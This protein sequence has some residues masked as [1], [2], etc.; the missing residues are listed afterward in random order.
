MRAVRPFGVRGVAFGGM[1]R[2]D[3]VRR[4]YDAG[5]AHFVANP[6]LDLLAVVRR[7][8]A[9]DPAPRP[10]AAVRRGTGPGRFGFPVPLNR[11]ASF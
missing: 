6:A 11:L 4:A 1:A 8:L 2:P 9:A 10:R 5:F 7:L 3:D